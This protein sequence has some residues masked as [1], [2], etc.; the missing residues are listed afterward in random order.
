[1]IIHWRESGMNVGR[2]SFFRLFFRFFFFFF[3]K[4]FFTGAFFSTLRVGIVICF[5]FK[6]YWKFQ[7]QKHVMTSHSLF[8]S[9]CYLF[10]LFMEKSN[11][12][13][14]TLK[15]EYDAVEFTVHRHLIHLHFSNN[16]NF[17]TSLCRSAYSFRSFSLR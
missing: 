9:F 10:H 1:M 13:F 8:I 14:S 3:C 5:T 15:N 16:L 11:Q 4:I 12:T 6:L 17:F 2:F 7:K